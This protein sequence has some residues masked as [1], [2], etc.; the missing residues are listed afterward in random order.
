METTKRKNGINS[1][2]LHILAMGFMLCDHL[3]ATVISNAEWLSWLGRIA[4]PIFA[5]LIVEGF[6]HT[7]SFKKYLLRM[8]LFAL[9]SEIPF[10]LMYGGSVFYPVHQNALWTFIIAL[11]SVKAI[12][13]VKKK[14]K[15]RFT[16]PTALGVTLL[17]VLAGTVLM[18]D[19]FGFGVLTVILFYFLRGKSPWKILILVA[20][21]WYI[22]GVLLGGMT[23][24][25]DLLGFSFDFPKQ[26][27]AML[28]LIPILLYNGERGPKTKATQYAFYA[29]Y[30]LHMLI[31]SGM[32]LW[33]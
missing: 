28:S 16:M 5:F 7:K 3:W 18:T 6:Y 1:F 29:F 11:L 22:N 10:N 8:F 20:G 32:T 9:I 24:P 13:T 4:F 14:N 26:A 23:V 2:T 27:V 19:Y 17:G 15:L 31:L 25:V 30:P 21:L 12:D 33:L